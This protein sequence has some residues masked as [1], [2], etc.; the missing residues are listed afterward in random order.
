AFWVR[1]HYRVSAG[2]PVGETRSNSASGTMTYPGEADVA[3]IPLG[4]SS[5]TVGFRTTP[6]SLTPPGI[7]AS[8]APASV[9]GDGQ[10]VPGSL[11][12]FGVG[13]TTSALPL[14]SSFTPQYVFIAPVG[15]EIQPGSAS[16][17]SGSVP[18]GV[19]FD[20]RTVEIGGVDRQIV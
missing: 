14:D 18:A 17:P 15:W 12:T 7:S 9:A 8:N 11:V 6:T 16:F 4:P 10:A 20:Y 3:D 5:R 2:A 19:V 13:G 1:F